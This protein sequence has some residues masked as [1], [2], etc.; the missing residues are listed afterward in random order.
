[1]SDQKED[2]Q[3][4]EFQVI[5]LGRESMLRMKAST[6]EWKNGLVRLIHQNQNVAVFLAEQV[7][8]LI[9]KE[10]RVDAPSK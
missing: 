3:L 10:Y 5:L 9:D 8:G 2:H 1:M 4:R 6:F 7:Q